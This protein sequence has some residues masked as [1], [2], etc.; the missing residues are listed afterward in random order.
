MFR[1]TYELQRLDIFKHL[2][3]KNYQIDEI[4]WAGGDNYK[5]TCIDAN[6]QLI[7]FTADVHTQFQVIYS[8]KVVAD[9]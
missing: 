2:N 7:E 9:V 8:L 6:D 4:V 1:S 5:L 3:G